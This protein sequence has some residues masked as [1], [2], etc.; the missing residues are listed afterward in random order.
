V[1]KPEDPRLMLRT[2]KL[3]VDRKGRVGV[4]LQC[5]DAPCA[6]TVALVDT[7]RK[8]ATNRVK[9]TLAPGQAKT[10]TLR[11]TTATRKALRKRSL[12]VRI[13]TAPTAGTPLTDKRTLPKTRSRR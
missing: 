1:I 7:A 8:R 4:R 9:Y 6:G 3:K 12:G 10:L 13:T 5:A 11:L 2:T